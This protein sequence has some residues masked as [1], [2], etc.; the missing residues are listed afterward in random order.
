MFIRILK[1]LLCKRLARDKNKYVPD[2]VRLEV[3]TEVAMKN[4]VS[5]VG[6]TMAPVF[7]RDLLPLPS[8][9]TEEIE[10]SCEMLTCLL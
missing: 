4:M 1:N 5:W 6:R 7:W 3:L 10:R 2:Y 9:Y 8:E